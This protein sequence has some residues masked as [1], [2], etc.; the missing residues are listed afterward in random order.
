MKQQQQQH[1]TTTKGTNN[2]NDYIRARYDDM[3]KDEADRSYRLWSARI[4]MRP[5]VLTH[6]LRIARIK[7][8]LAETR[9][10]KLESNV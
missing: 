8:L 10:G 9:Q 7:R 1:T 6:E 5:T 4:S 3:L 2:M